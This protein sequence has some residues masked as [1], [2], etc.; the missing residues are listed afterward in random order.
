MIAA[1]R[2]LA[3][4][5]VAAACNAADPDVRVERQ[6]SALADATDTGWQTGGAVMVGAAGSFA[7]PQHVAL[8]VSLV[9]GNS[10]DAEGVATALPIDTVSLELHGAASG[11][12]SVEPT[13][14]ALACTAELLVL[15]AGTTMLEVTATGADEAEGDCFYYAVQEDADPAAASAALR[16]ELET[17]Q[18]ACRKLIQQR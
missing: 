6:A 14:D 3:I 4:L 16:T 10:V 11:D 17:Q 12:V 2:M 18:A 5:V 7:F 15:E 13:C 8:R 9:D 1:M